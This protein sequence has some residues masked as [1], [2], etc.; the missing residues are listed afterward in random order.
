[1]RSAITSGNA[2]K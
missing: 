2:T 1:M